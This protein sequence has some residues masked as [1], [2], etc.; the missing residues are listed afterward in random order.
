MQTVRSLYPFSLCMEIVA[1]DQLPTDLRASI[2]TLMRQLYIEAETRRLRPNT[3]S[4]WDWDLLLD[5]PHE[6]M[7]PPLEACLSRPPRVTKGVALQPP[8]RSSERRSS[9]RDVRS[10]YAESSGVN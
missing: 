5:G 10:G 4:V 7:I 2:C 6:Q 1:N 3:Q 9:E 8:W